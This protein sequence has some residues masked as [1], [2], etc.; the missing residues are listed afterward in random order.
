MKYKFSVLLIL[1][2]LLTGCVFEPVQ[3][4]SPATEAPETQPP[5]YF[6]VHYLDVGQADATLIVCDGEYLLMDGGNNADASLIYAYL[7][8]M[9][10][11]HLRFLICTHPHEDHVGGLAAALNFASVDTVYCPV[12]EA[13]LEE[14]RNFRN[15]LD[16]QN[17]PITVPV[18]G[19]EFT[20]GSALCTIV[21]VNTCPDHPND[22]S[23]VLK[24]RYGSTVFLFSG[25]AEARA[26]Q[27]IVE[28][29]ADISCTVMKVPHHGSDSSL[30]DQWLTAAGP[31]YTVISCGDRNLY[32]HP[33]TS[34]LEKLRTAGVTL[35]RTDLQGHIICQSDGSRVHFTTARNSD[36]DTYFLPPPPETEPI[37]E[38]T[39]YILNLNSMVFHRISCS[40]CSKIAQKNRSQTSLSREE[41]IAQGFSPCGSC[42]P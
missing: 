28:S 7:K 15:Y 40:S 17:V 11:R 1:L 19:T 2:F 23:I 21:A 35:F 10:A 6:E 16:M 42:M 33:H 41:L 36:A 24:V 29:G 8:D 5:G 37:G 13:E 39:T 9:D 30:T 4:A 20:L 31:Q 18:P 32:S 12:Q 26:E 14:F 25:D 22:S 3:T 34:T 27:L 38:D